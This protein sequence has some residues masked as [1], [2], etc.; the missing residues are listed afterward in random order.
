MPGGSRHPPGPRREVTSCLPGRAPGDQGLQVRRPIFSVSPSFALGTHVSVAAS[1]LKHSIN[2]S[3]YGTHR[4]YAELEV[5]L[6]GCWRPASAHVPS[7]RRCS[8]AQ[9]GDPPLGG[10]CR[11]PCSPRRPLALGPGWVVLVGF[12]KSPSFWEKPAQTPS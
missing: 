7:R 11:G 5:S 9:L 10:S 12:P 4:S 2:S 8:R 1:E 3:R 6:A